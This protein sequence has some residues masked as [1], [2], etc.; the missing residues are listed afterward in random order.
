MAAFFYFYDRTFID[1]FSSREKVGHIV[2]TASANRSK[3]KTS[4]QYVRFCDIASNFPFGE[5]NCLLYVL[6]LFCVMSICSIMYKHEG[7]VAIASLSCFF[8]CPMVKGLA[9]FCFP[10]QNA[11]SVL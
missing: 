7:M 3:H 9:R 10:F 1:M 2:I 6:H 11:V 5:I 4:Q 8:Y